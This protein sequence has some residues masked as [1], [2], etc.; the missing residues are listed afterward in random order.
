MKWTKF[1]YKATI[2]IQ[3]IYWTKAIFC[4]PRKSIGLPLLKMVL[5][6]FSVVT[7]LPRS[8]HLHWF[9][10]ISNSPDFSFQG[11]K[12]DFRLNHLHVTQHALQYFHDPSNDQEFHRTEHH[13]KLCFLR[14]LPGHM[15]FCCFDCHNNNHCS[16]SIED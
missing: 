5:Y 1:K 3:L 13:Q 16:P 11:S 14:F 7:Y 12:S 15:I 6:V 4:H 9:C 10:L 2:N 8:F